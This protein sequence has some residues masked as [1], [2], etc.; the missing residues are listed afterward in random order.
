M[1]WGNQWGSEAV[2]SKADGKQDCGNMRPRAIMQRLQEKEIGHFLDKMH[3]KSG[4]KLYCTFSG[5]DHAVC[6]LPS[7]VFANISP[8]FTLIHLLIC[9]LTHICLKIHT[10]CLSVLDDFC[11][12]IKYVL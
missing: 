2:G 1:Q 12:D 8:Y 9:L 3:K 7:A 10:F 11:V 4:I 5:V 6:V